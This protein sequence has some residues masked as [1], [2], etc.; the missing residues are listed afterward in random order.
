MPITPTYPGVYIEELPGGPPAIT[1]VATSIGAFVDFFPQGPLK[2]AVRLL[3]WSDFERQF[4]GLDTRSEASYGIQQFFLN[5]GS[6][7]YAVRAT[8]TT[9]GN[10]AQ[11][12]A[13]VLQDGSIGILEATAGT[14]G[15]WGNNLRI[16]IDYGTNDPTSQFNLTVTEVSISGGVTQTVATEPFRNLTLDSTQSNYA[17][18][19]VQNGSQLITLQLLSTVARPAQTGTTSPGFVAVGLAW[20]AGTIFT[21]GTMIVDANGYLEQASGGLSGTTAVTFPTAIGGTVQ[22]GAI[23]WQKVATGSGNAHAANTAYSLGV[24]VSDGGNWFQAVAVAGTSGP[25]NPT[26]PPI[27]PTNWPT[28]DGGTVND[29]SVVWQRVTTGAGL[30][31]PW[32]SGTAYAAGAQIID[33]NGNRQLTNAGGVSGTS[34]PTAGWSHTN[35]GTDTTTDG[36]VTWTLQNGNGLAVALPAILTVSL[37]GVAFSNGFTLNAPSPL[38]TISWS[39]LT[40]ALQAN[41]RAVDPSLANATVTL[42]GSAASMAFLQ[43]KPNTGNISDFLSLSDAA[44]STSTLAAT[45]QVTPT[46]NGV[47]VQQYALGSSMAVHAQALPAGVAQPGQDG[48]WDPFADAAGVTGGLIGDQLQKNGMYALL[49]VDLF[50]ILCIPVTAL[51]PDT[52][53]SAIASAATALCVGRRAFYILDVPQQTNRDTVNGIVD[54]LGLNATLRSRNAALYFPRLDIADPLNRFQLRKVAPSGTIAGIY[55]STDLSRGVWKAPAGT[56][57]SLAGVQSLE[58]NL[59]DAENGVLNPLA[60]NCVRNFPV[61]GIICWGARTSYGADQLEDEYK[62]VPVRRLA[63]YLEESLYRGTKWVVF[64]PNDEPLWAQIRLSIG[65][66]MQDL[67]LQGAFQGSTPQAAYLVKC[68]SETTTALDQARGVV[69]ILI[70][71]APLKPAEFVI[72]QIQQLAGQTT[73]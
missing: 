38:T 52:N 53:A 19:V 12:A 18:N 8:S 62:Y 55:A 48:L 69:N 10:G 40:T 71:F 2:T 70:G 57:A 34:P 44:T 6:Q 47:N 50:N 43:L 61:Y 49:D 41:I 39:W 9:P 1:G 24:I 73:T 59:I 45:L 72:L 16:D 36:T 21:Q 30:L 27:D 4:G 3:S 32:F 60:I 20:T 68:D 42:I 5:G 35:F 64:E 7:A 56:Q 15:A 17:V 14:P 31:Q 58:Y 26:P 29:G 46:S 23:T 37:N 11:A 65:A 54:W 28:V 66:F 25:P 13:I 33:P 63:L 67:F 51:L 22:D